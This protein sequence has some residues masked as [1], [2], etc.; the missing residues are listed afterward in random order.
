MAAGLGGGAV[1]VVGCQQLQ[2]E[3]GHQGTSTWTAAG[4]A[5]GGAG[6]VR[7][8]AKVEGGRN[9]PLLQ[10]GHQQVQVVTAVRGQQ[11]GH[12]HHQPQSV[13]MAPPGSTSVSVVHAI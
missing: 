11:Q 1:Q 5:F 9:T 13:A 2:I 10:P 12:Q 3:R 8:E 7:P 4:G 6:G